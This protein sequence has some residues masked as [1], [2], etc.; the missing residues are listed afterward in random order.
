MIRRLIGCAVRLVRRRQL[1]LLG[2]RG[3][4]FETAHP[5][6]SSLGAQMKAGGYR[7]KRKYSLRAVAKTDAELDKRRRRVD[8][9]VSRREREAGV[10]RI[11]RRRRAS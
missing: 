5:D 1:P 4:P 2:W 8:V 11:K 3:D 9:A 7:P 6:G 10:L